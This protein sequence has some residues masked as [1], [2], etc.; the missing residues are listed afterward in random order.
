MSL[1]MESLEQAME[2]IRRHERFLLIPHERADGD[3]LG[4]MLALERAINNHGKGA[5]AVIL[6]PLSER[7]QFLAENRNLPLAGKDLAWETLK[8]ADGVIVIDTG[9]KEQLHAALPFL[10]NCPGELMVIDHHSYCD[11]SPK[12]TLIEKGSPATGLIIAQLLD[13][14]GWLDDAQMA[15]NLLVAIVTDTG[16]FSYSNTTADCYAWAAKLIALGADDRAIY[17]KLFLSDSPQRFRL[18]ARALS[19]AEL[20]CDDRLIVLTLKQDD[21]R[22]AGACEAHTENVIDQACRIKPMVAAI[23][24][25]EQPNDVVRISMRSRAPFDVHAF[26]SQFGGGGHPRASGMRIV[27]PFD[28][29][30]ANVIAKLE[31]AILKNE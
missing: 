19:S 6:T 4:S 21:F 1:T 18:I 5:R 8:S 7:Y 25:V 3:A 24:F 31:S 13:A 10:D 14:M 28:E 23:L 27:G 12:T 29:V 16:W 9:A 17:E 22:Q 2:F 11:L 26:A 15:E 20:H 30:R